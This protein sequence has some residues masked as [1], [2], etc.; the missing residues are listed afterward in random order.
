MFTKLLAEHDHDEGEGDESQEV[1]FEF[2]IAGGDSAELFEFIKK[3]FDFVAL[4]V[5][6]LIVDDAIQAVRLGRDERGDTLGVELG[7]D[8]VAVVGF[9]H[10][11]VP[12][13]VARIEGI[14]PRLADRSVSRRP[15]READLDPIGFGGT[16]GMD[17]G[18]ESA[19]RATQGLIAFFLAAPAAC[20]CA[21]TTVE[22]KNTMLR[23]T[24]LSRFSNPRISPQTPRAIQRCPRM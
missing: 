22:S 15:R 16:H 6:F 19:P 10:G 14:D 11:G 8:G 7:A 17:L 24:P 5:A 23:S 21:R 18:A 12:D 13:A 4:F 3:A 20:W 9:V 1:D 2:F